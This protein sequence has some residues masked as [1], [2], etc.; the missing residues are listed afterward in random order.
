MSFGSYLRADSKTLSRDHAKRSWSVGMTVQISTGISPMQKRDM[1]FLIQCEA[2]LA[3]STPLKNNLPLA[4]AHPRTAAMPSDLCWSV[5]LGFAEVKPKL[6][7]PTVI[8]MRPI[9]WSPSFT[10][11]LY[12]CINV[13]IPIFESDVP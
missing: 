3:F 7:N 8:N 12:S 2:G 5:G 1:E 6:T 9:I 4:L 13:P 11:L 10:P